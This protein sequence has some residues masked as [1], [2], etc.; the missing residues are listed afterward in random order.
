VDGL[1][2]LDLPLSSEGWIIK[3]TGMSQQIQ[4]F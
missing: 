4:E 3:H 2:W 1:C